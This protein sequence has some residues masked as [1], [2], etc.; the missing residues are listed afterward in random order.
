M[1]ILWI[2]NTML[3]IIAEQLGLEVC[4]KEGWL[5]GLCDTI[6]KNY[7]NNDIELHIAFPID[8]ETEENSGTIVT[9]TKR[10][11][12]EPSAGQLKEPAAATL[13][14]HAFKEDIR[15][16]E[17][18]DEELEVRLRE[19]INEV[20]PDVIHCFGTEFAHTLA[21][22]RCCGKPEK[23]VVGLQGICTAIAES[24]M[25]DLPEK[26]Q[27]SVSFRDLLKKDSIRQ[28]QHKYVMRGVR[29]QEVISRVGNVIGRTEFDRMYAYKFNPEIN[30]F[31]MNETL[32]QCFYEGQW[33]AESC[34]PHTIFVSQADYPLKGF[35]YL[36]L[37]A[38]KLIE[39][40]PDLE[41]RVAGNSLVNYA[42]LKDKIKISAYGKYLRRLIKDEGLEGRVHFAGMLSAEQ[43]KEEYLNCGLFVCCSSNE[44]SPNSLGEAMLLGVPCVAAMV[45]GIPSLFENGVDGVGFKGFEADL[46]PDVTADD[47]RLYN[48]SEALKNAVCEI[49]D[50]P[51]K[52]QIFCENARKH[53]K[54]THNSKANYEKMV[55][56]YS[57]I[58]ERTRK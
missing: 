41:I 57:N 45:G 7:D 29:E 54:T 39:K 12:K 31:L 24:Y 36:L 11:L 1:K 19:I 33:R 40:Y 3:P 58:A 22:V 4:N 47:S 25:A 51:E 18:Y 5:T 26:V 30:Y 38:G 43:M 35:H 48:V 49:W 17:R 23:I 46:R 34:K 53:A 16:A 56:I 14:Y 8:G 10:Q 52:R 2:C 37:A 28:Q 20:D 9:D 6:L 55:E 50:N 32:R 21:V 44:N 27:N 13:T 15:N 42:T